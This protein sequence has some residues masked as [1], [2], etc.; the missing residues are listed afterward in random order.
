MDRRSLL[1][2]LIGSAASQV[3]AAFPLR[4]PAASPQARPRIALTM[5]DPAV[6]LN[7]HM[8]WPEANH[9][10]LDLLAKRKLR[11]ALFVC[12][13]R[14]N[15]P[16]GKELLG[17]W[18]DAGHLLCSHSYS[19]LNLNAQATSYDAF[20]ADFLRNE[21]IL[22]P[23]R[24]RARL[25]RFPGLKEG[26]TIEKR[27]GFRAFLKQN[28][29]RVG[30]VTVDASD[31]YV[32][33]RM[34]RRIKQDSGAALEPYRDYL[35]NHLLERASYYRRLALDVLGREI[36]HTLLVHYRTINAL[37][38]PDVMSAFE[39]AGWEWID[40]KRAF[41]DSIFLREPK[42]LPAG[43]SLIWA[44]AAENGNF[45]ARLRYP[46]EDDAYEKARM[47]ALGLQ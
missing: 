43:E 18:D 5:D 32:D 38:L 44:L 26:D 30:A 2:Y 4:L 41:D 11:I 23:Y 34:C 46:G 19:H 15:Q 33:D 45:G 42:T 7:S 10:L 12:G 21:P 17:Q 22:S 6:T 36:C 25:F 29:Y 39:K 31:W 9:R 8:Q 27:D 35:M 28:S 13:M 20:V 3:S 24:H 16:G 37:F 14:V 1:H 47:D 40:A